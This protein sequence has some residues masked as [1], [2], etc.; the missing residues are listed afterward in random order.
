[1]DRVIFRIA[2]SLFQEFKFPTK[3][4]FKNGKNNTYETKISIKIFGN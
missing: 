4:L 2:S 1:M 3:N